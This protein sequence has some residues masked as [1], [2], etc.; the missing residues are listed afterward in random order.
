MDIETIKFD[1]YTRSIMEA[2]AVSPK[3]FFCLTKMLDKTSEQMYQELHEDILKDSILSTRVR[4]AERK[5]A[6]TSISV[7]DSPFWHKYYNEMYAYDEFYLDIQN[8]FDLVCA[9]R[10]FYD[11][12]ERADAEYDDEVGELIVH[13]FEMPFTKKSYDEVYDAAIKLVS[14]IE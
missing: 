14:T 8:A 1:A 7:V 5:L 12:P 3:V 2:S 6:R 13:L 4:L 11:N 9:L 10:E